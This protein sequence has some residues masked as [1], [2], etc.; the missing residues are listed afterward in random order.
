MSAD[1][2]N[3]TPIRPGTPVTSS[4]LTPE[5]RREMAANVHAALGRLAEKADKGRTES[6]APKK[7]RPAAVAR[8]KD[9]QARR[10]ADMS[11]VTPPI[12]AAG[13]PTQGL[14]GVALVS[15]GMNLH[16]E[17]LWK[18]VSLLQCLATAAQEETCEDIGAAIEAARVYAQHIHLGFG[19]VWMNFLKLEKEA[20][21]APEQ[22]P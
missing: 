7:A 21:Q 9:R 22:T 20:T 6:K 14:T 13:K 18:M 3:V 17:D 19:T 5:A 15:H 1:N 10:E 4:V 2:D 8:K 11:N 12:T 16:N